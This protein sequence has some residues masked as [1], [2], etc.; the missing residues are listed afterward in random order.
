M[1]AVWESHSFPNILQAK[2]K[3]H[4]AQLIEMRRRKHFDDLED[5]FDDF[6]GESVWF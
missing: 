2:T 5:L 3:N 4:T 6:P 1:I